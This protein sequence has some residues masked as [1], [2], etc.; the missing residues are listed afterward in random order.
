MTIGILQW[1][2]SGYV[3]PPGHYHLHYSTHNKRYSSAYMPHSIEC[4]H[5]L[6]RGLAAL[7]QRTQLSMICRL[8]ISSVLCLPALYWLW[9]HSYI[10]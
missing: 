5:D 10:K 8:V 1:S 7:F 6:I 2:Y 9:S 4:E 3:I